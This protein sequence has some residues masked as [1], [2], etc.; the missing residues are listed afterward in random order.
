MPTRFVAETE[1]AEEEKEGALALANAT[2]KAL[3][4]RDRSLDPIVKGTAKSGAEYFIG[5]SYHGL[6]IQGNSSSPEP[7]AIGR[8]GKASGYDDEKT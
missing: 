8:S 6:E 7:Y 3:Q 5:R 2:E 4:L 1:N